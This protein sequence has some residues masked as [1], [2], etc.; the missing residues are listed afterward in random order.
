MK[1]CDIIEHVAST[2]PA[3]PVKEGDSGCV[4]KEDVQRVSRVSLTF[5]LPHEHF[6]REL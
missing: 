5:D 2:S 3:L 1:M 4:K 6:C